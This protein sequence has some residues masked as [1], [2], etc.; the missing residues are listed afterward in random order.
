MELEYRHINNNDNL[1]DVFEL[2]YSGD[3][4]I[5]R[6]LFTNIDDGYKIFLRI[7]KNPNSMFF[8]EHYRVVVNE[9]TQQVLGVCSFFNPDVKWDPS[10]VEQAYIMS[11]VHIPESFDSVSK[12]FTKTYNY[13]H[14][15]VGA[16]N[17]CVKEGCRGQHVGSFMLNSL[18]EEIENEDVQL[19]VLKDNVAAIKL[20]EK[21]G[22]QIVSEFMDY[23][24]HNEPEVPCYQMYRFSK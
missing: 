13:K 16:C 5:Y 21:Y 10:I 15:L 14:Y 20:Y 7:C 18:L 4:Y 9:E 8:V 24:G 6:D 19:T 11:G 12:Y 23:G 22:F 1:R 17:V 3:P 2:I